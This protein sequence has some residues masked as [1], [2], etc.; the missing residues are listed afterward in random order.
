M[1]TPFLRKRQQISE[2]ERL[3]RLTDA[4]RQLTYLLH[5]ALADADPPLAHALLLELESATTSLQRLERLRCHAPR[6]RA[7]RP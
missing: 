2:R 6:C 5:E 7:L 1:P 3:T 4:A